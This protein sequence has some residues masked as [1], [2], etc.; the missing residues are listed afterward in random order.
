MAWRAIVE[1]KNTRLAFYE[2]LNASQKGRIS[3]PDEIPAWFEDLNAL[4]TNHLKRCE[5]IEYHHLNY[6]FID[7]IER[8]NIKSRPNR[9]TLQTVAKSYLGYTPTLE[10]L[11]EMGEAEF[12]AVMAEITLFEAGLKASG[13]TGTL[14]E[15]VT[16]PEQFSANPVDIAVVYE[17]YIAKGEQDL[18]ARF[19]DYD[20][21]K[22]SANVVLGAQRWG[23]FASY[24]RK[25]SA[26]K[27]YFTGAKYDL[28]IAAFISVHEIFPGHH[29]A[30]SASTRKRLCLG[31]GPY[32]GSWLLEGWA[33][34]AEFIAEEEGFFD[35]P[36]DK[37]SWLD[38]RLT[39]AIRIIL[40]VKRMQGVT[41]YK[42]LK[43][44]WNERMPERLG[45]RFD[46]EYK[47]LT[48]SRHQ[49]LS[50]ILGYRA[51]M[52]VKTKLMQELGSEFDEKVF[53][54]AIL[55]LTHK[56]PLVFYETVKIAMEL[57]KDDHDFRDSLDLK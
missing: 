9:I 12:T 6:R 46:R 10:A 18:A 3:N 57:S 40:D 43:T 52:D 35:K 26:M 20:I 22:G 32:V 31:D 42:A 51:I 4:D 53:H 45:E 50:Y 23:S 39:R 56:E 41:E 48:G 29:L 49:H 8:L 7:R 13:Y 25:N 34:Y 47:R 16:Q 27:A 54:D 14:K 5:L 17:D 37:L 36:A 19:Y 1:P 21:P 28:N 44:I 24:D 11:S 30:A 2:I 33:T 55:R 15:L 38:Y